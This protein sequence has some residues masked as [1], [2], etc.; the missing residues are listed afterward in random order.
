[1]SYGPQKLGTIT[2]DVMG[3]EVT[4]KGAR[5][6]PHVPATQIDPPEHEF[7]EWDSVFVGESEITELFCYKPNAD[8]LHEA[9]LQ[10]VE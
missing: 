9:I 5:Y 7:A 1:M 3:I 6:Y 4:V 10:A 8:R 2:I